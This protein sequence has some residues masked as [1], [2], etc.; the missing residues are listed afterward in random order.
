[1]DDLQMKLT[2]LG[3]EKIFDKLGDEFADSGP[4]KCNT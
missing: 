1:M 4:R 3:D 2:D